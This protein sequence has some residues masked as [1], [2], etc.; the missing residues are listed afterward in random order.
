MKD[1][2]AGIESKNTLNKNKLVYDIFRDN[3][4]DKDFYEE[5]KAEIIAYET[6]L[7]A[8]K[9]S[10][11]D[12]LDI[13]KYKALESDKDELMEKYSTQNTTIYY[14]QNLKKNTDKYIENE[15]DIIY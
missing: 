12:N 5:Y 1:I 8:L 4:D 11:Y 10:D 9:K 15:R 3:K 14:L 13:K 7:N 2:Y 6:A